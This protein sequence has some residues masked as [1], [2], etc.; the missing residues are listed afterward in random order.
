MQKTLKVL[1]SLK[2]EWNLTPL[3]LCTHILKYRCPIIFRRKM[4]G[5]LPSRGSGLVTPPSS[6]KSVSLLR[7]K[8]TNSSASKSN[9]VRLTT[10]ATSSVCI[11]NLLYLFHMMLVTGN[12]RT[13]AVLLQV[14]QHSA[15]HDI[16]NGN[17][18]GCM[19][20]EEVE[21]HLEAK[22]RQVL[23][24]PEKTSLT[25]PSEMFSSD[26][27]MDRWISAIIKGPGQSDKTLL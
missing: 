12:H 6:S 2:V 24:T 23:L 7:K 14:S 18:E 3:L 16:I 9:A 4:E 13:I 17:G 11:P 8:K 1:S 15:S 20:P 26:I 10:P 22:K 19:T 25:L 5:S 21:R 27:T